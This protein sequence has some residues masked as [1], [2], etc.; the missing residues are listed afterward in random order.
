MKKLF[1][2][3]AMFLLSTIQVQAEDNNAALYDVTAPADSAFVRVFN[4]SGQ[5]VDVRLSSKSKAQKVSGFQ[6]GE[7]L[8]T[9]EGS[10]TLTVESVSL[11]IELSKNQVTTFLFDGTKLTLIEDEFFD[12]VKKAHV[13]FYNFTSN[14]LSLKTSNGKHS[15]VKNVLSEKNGTRKVNEIKMA[16]SAFSDDQKMADFEKTFLKKGRSYSYVVL[17][18]NGQIQ[19]LVQPNLVSV[20]E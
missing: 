1:L 15:L 17:D 14:T 2:I 8:F 10:Y 13:T 3:V 4:N 9:A 18:H 19:T 7:Y 12:G 11:P 16:F 20:I 5:S 6:L